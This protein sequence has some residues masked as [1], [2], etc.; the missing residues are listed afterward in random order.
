MEALDTHKISLLRNEELQAWTTHIESFNC[1]ILRSEHPRL[2]FE[3]IIHLLKRNI[4]GHPVF[5]DTASLKVRNEQTNYNDG[6]SFISF[7]AK[8]YMATFFRNV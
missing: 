2:F 8:V 4:P 1:L 5:T 3:N 6:P 7:P